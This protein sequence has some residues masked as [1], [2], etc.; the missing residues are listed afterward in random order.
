MEALKQEKNTTVWNSGH[1]VIQPSTKLKHLKIILAKKFNSISI[2]QTISRYG[3]PFLHI[4]KP[5][6]RSE[7]VQGMEFLPC[8]HII[9]TVTNE[10]AGIQVT[11]KDSG[12][13]NN[14]VLF[15]LHSFHG[16]VLA[17]EFHRS[18]KCD[19]STYFD[20][21]SR[22]A[23]DT[24]KLC[25]GIDEIDKEPFMN[26]IQTCD[27]P[28]LNKFKS[29][30]LIEQ[31]MGTILVRSRLCKFV[32]Y[33][34]DN[35]LK[36][37]KRSNGEDHI[38]SF[39]C[40][41]EC[42]SFQFNTQ[43][44]QPQNCENKSGIVEQNSFQKVFSQTSISDM[45]ALALIQRVNEFP[46]LASKHLPQCTERE[47]KLEEDTANSTSYKV[48]DHDDNIK[49]EPNAHLNV[50]D[51]TN[52]VSEAAEIRHSNILLNE[53][54]SYANE[55]NYPANK[56]TA[57]SDG[58]NTLCLKGSGDIENT[59]ND[60]NFYLEDHQHLGADNYLDMHILNDPAEQYY[61]STPSPERRRLRKKKTSNMEI[62]A[63][64]YEPQYNVPIKDRIERKKIRLEKKKGI[65]KGIQ[66]K[67]RKSSEQQVASTGKKEFRR[68]CMICLYEFQSECNF[69]TDQLRHQQTFEDMEQSVPC[70]LCHER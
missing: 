26:F 54:P 6:C 68:T 43:E 19:N 37:R 66:P 49:I 63:D 58:S 36:I 60:D 11:P 42:S 1:T 53:N 14:T 51:G 44:N 15:Q 8:F 57:E 30:F 65:L 48:S 38:N 23:G 56:F 3:V 62:H 55:Y 61:N 41:Q 46:S 10:H 13:R 28:L 12:G 18:N 27:L 34:D 17:E 9:V 69:N 35:S 67:K 24:L 21:V 20:L 5:I 47:F 70:P 31:F 64:I 33:D 7:G 2:H 16:K 40:C 59:G 45:E 52:N 50:I 22:M 32:L 39:K 4:W 29:V 25:H